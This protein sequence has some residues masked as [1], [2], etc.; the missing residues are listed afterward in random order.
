MWGALFPTS[1]SSGICRRRGKRAGMLGMSTKSREV[2]CGGRILGAEI[3]AVGARE[4]AQKANREADR[5]E[6]DA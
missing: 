3:R 4:A 1:N 6:A 5:A 2:I